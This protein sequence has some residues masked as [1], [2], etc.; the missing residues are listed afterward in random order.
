MN[1]HVNA[2]ALGAVPRGRQAEVA[3]F[4]SHAG[5][6]CEALDGVGNVAVPFIS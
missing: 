3:H 2:D 1:V 4:G 6:R 5:K